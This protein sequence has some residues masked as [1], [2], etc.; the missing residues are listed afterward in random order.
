MFLLPTI[1]ALAADDLSYTVLAPLPCI[2]S[3]QDCK[4]AATKTE[5]KDY[6]PGIFK[7]AI[8]LSAVA[9]VLMIVIGGFQYISSDA[10]MGKKDGKER[11]KNAVFGLVLV[12]SAWLILN[13]I[14]PNLLNINLNIESISTTALDGGTLG[15][16]G[17]SGSGI[18]G[19]VDILKED[20][21]ANHVQIAT[22]LSEYNI[23]LN[24]GVNGYCKEGSTAC[25][26]INGLPSDMISALGSLNTWCGNTS[27]PLV[28]SGGT[29]IYAHVGHGPG[30]SV[31]DIRPT[32]QLN[33]KLLGDRVGTL[34]NGTQ[35]TIILQGGNKVLLFT[36]EVA[37]AGNSTGDH[38]HVVLK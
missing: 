23:T 1:V 35:A 5:L 6:I 12:I 18:V 16:E 37:G 34:K 25:T 19:A 13:T 33:N 17:T 28:I 36:Y 8:G 38:W 27:C 32:A 24:R 3:D 10:I 29:E 31:V 20:Q 14:N 7:L 9:A 15:T 4:T 30:K 21:I 22:R 2:G 11:I 26:N